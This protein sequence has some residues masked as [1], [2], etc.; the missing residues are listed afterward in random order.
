MLKVVVIISICVLLFSVVSLSAIQVK[1]SLARNVAYQQLSRIN[2]D[3]SICI[4]GCE[5]LKLNETTLGYVFE[6]E[7]T[8]YVVVSADDRISPVIAY[9]TEADFYTV[10][11]ANNILAEIVTADLT[12]RLQYAETLSDLQKNQFRNE[13][14]PFLQQRDRPPLQQWPPEGSTVT[15]G[16]VKTRWNQSAPYNALCPMD[17]VTNHR[18]VAG[19]PAVAMGQIVN[20]YGTVNGITFTDTD[21][22]HHNY[23]GNNYWIDNDSTAFGFPSFASLNRYLETAVHHYRY[24]EEITN[25]DKAAV[26]FGCAVAATQVFGSAGSG[27]FSVNQAMSAYQR[28]NF[29]GMELL[30]PSDTNVNDRI[31]QNMMD[32]RPVHYAIVTPANDAGHNVVVD[33]YNTDGFFHVNFGWGGQYDGWYLLP[34]GLPYNLT[35]LEGAIVDIQPYRF[36]GVLPESVNIMTLDDAMAPHEMILWNDST[37]GNITVEAYEFD[38]SFANTNWVVTGLNLPVTLAYGETIN[39][40]LQA[41]YTQLH[42]DTLETVFRIIHNNGVVNIPVR[43]NSGIVNNQ[44]YA[45]PIASDMILKQNYP[46]PFNHITTFDFSLS[47]NSAV[48]IAIYN[49]KGERIR[50]L[51]NGTMTKGNHTFSWDGKDINGNICSSGMY[52]YKVK[53]DSAECSKRMMFIK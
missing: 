15:G 1:E 3:R 19:C 37:L 53:S 39:F 32:A 7:P 35:V 9:S 42:R 41:N 13:W 46:N 8:G 49:L 25:T 17:N 22:Y 20:Y 21:D 11:D 52:V 27:T 12:Y 4:T 36:A 18:S 14:M 44:D 28:F 50:T 5:K 34:T 47:K 30:T 29:T 40:T 31:A 33:G 24:Q 6:L 38:Q 51:S 45:V 48:T 26:I 2:A 16:W 43:W 23:G 10:S